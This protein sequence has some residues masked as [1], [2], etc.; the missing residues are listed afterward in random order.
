MASFRYQRIVSQIKHR[1]RN[2]TLMPGA[3]LP[4]VRSLSQREG[5]SVSTVLRAYRQL[6]H[7]G[8]IEAHARS[9]YYVSASRSACNVPQSPEL[10]LR[11]RRVSIE[12]LVESVLTTASQPALVSFGAAIP[13][14]DLLPLDELRRIGG[15][16]QRRH[17]ASA[18]MTIEPGG[19]LAVRETLAQH[20]DSIGCRV[21]A[22]NVFVT[23]GC[24]DALALA[25]RAVA[26]AGDTIAIESPTYYGIPLLLRSLGMKAL[27]LPLSAA[28]VD[29]TAVQR[30]IRAGSAKAFVISANFQNPSGALMPDE[31]KSDLVDLLAS[32]Q[33]PLIEDDLY[34]DLSPP[35]S[36]RPKPLKAFDHGGHVLYCNSFSKTLAP[37]Y[38]VGW[39][40][41]GRYAKAV[42]SLQI[43]ATPAASGPAQ[44][45]I[46]E[47]LRC[48]A[49]TR[50]LRRLRRSIDIGVDQA[51]HCIDRHWPAAIR[52]ARPPGG[53]LLWVELPVATHAMRLHRQALD[54]GISVAPGPIFSAT[55][56][57]QHHIRLNCA[58]RWNDGLQQAMARLG[59]LIRHD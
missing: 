50:H 58:Q 35:N 42:R 18:A 59:K 55:G 2:A 47:Y 43:A 54:R 39:I 28:G 24:R 31:H 53:F 15:R 19:L 22:A 21:P 25:L 26:R 10:P 38:R 56:R 17:P 46:N 11:P 57:Y 4:S 6:E 30:V 36:A 13:G 5:L 23:H 16:A 51:L 29:L 34:G 40:A 41:P 8:V 3:R 45:A 48:G 33:V 49:Y 20:M 9:G 1:M 32:K 37:G 12:G 52:V 44:L 7:E 14:P 27:E